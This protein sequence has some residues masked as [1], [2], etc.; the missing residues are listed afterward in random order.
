MRVQNEA[1]KQHSDGCGAGEQVDRA[2]GAAA[3]ESRQ[4][5]DAPT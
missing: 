3:E 2:V 4:Q 5:V 1:N